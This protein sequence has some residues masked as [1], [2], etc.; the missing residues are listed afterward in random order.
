MINPK[1]VIKTLAY[2]T[3]SYVFYWIGSWAEF[4]TRYNPNSTHWF[5]YTFLPKIYSTCMSWSINL[6]EA[7]H[8]N[9][10]WIN[11]EDEHGKESV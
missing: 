10:P 8:L 6:Q 4:L 3:L 2:G 11:E 5:F 9:K 7:V 1:K